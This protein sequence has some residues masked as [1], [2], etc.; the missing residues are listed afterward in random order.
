MIQRVLMQTTVLR[1]LDAGVL[2]LTRDLGFEIRAQG[3][4][5]E[6]MSR[7]WGGDAAAHPRFAILSAPFVSRGFIRLVEGPSDDETGTFHKRG[8]FNAEL[9]TRDVEAL[10][11]RLSESPQFRVVSD[12]NTYDLS[13]AGGGAVSRSFATRGPGGAGFFFTQYL[14]VPPPRTL[15]VCETLVGPMFNAALSTPTDEAPVEAFY[16]D[17]LGMN[18][19]LAGRLTQPTVNRIIGLP[20]DWGFMMLVYKGEGDGLIEVDIHEHGVPAEP[21]RPDDHLRPGNS[22]LT[23]EASDLADIL[24]RAVEA[25][26]AATVPQAIVA[27]PYNNRRAAVL[28]GPAAERIELIDASPALT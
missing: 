5:D 16:H 15:P 8:L 3:A 14:K 28:R 22:M 26:F 11:A 23:V 19:R 9:L 2:A 24:A 20:D 6:G 7:I 25:G 1:D 13:G 21:V 18:R 10:H 12:L 4:V 27:A 17:V